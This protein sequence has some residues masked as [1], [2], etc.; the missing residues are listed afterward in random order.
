MTAHDHEPTT[1]PYA[2][3][4]ALYWNAGWRGVLPLPPRA[5]KSPPTG[6]TGRTQDWPT[7]PDVYAWTEDH[8]AGNL[9]LRLPHH[10]IGVDVDDYEGKNGATTLAALEA[11]FGSLPATWRT[12]SRD[13]G[14]SGIRLYRV[15]EGAAWPGDLGPGIE[16]IQWCHRYALVWPSVHPEA[17]TYRWVMPDGEDSI[18]VIPTPDDLPDLP[19]AWVEGLTHGRSDVATIKTALPAGAASVWLGQLQDRRPCRET[20]RA[21]T[22]YTTDLAPAD[23]NP[24]RSRHEVALTATMRLIRLAAEGHHGVPSALLAFKKAWARSLAGSRSTDEENGEWARLLEGAIAAVHTSPPAAA[25]PCANPFAGILQEG[26]WPNLPTPSIPQALATATGPGGPSTA[27]AGATA[28]TPTPAPGKE[29]GSPAA[30][31]GTSGSTSPAGAG[32]PAGAATPSPATSTTQTAEETSSAEEATSSPEEAERLAFEALARHQ[33]L[34]QELERQR[35]QRAAR[36]LLDEEEAVGGD[37]GSSEDWAPS[38]RPQD[39]TAHLDGSYAPEEP[40]LLPRTDG[41]HLLYPGRAHSLHGES[42]SGKSLVAQAEAARLLAAGHPV[43]YI[44]WEAD[45]GAIVGRLL[46]LGAPVAAIREQLTYIRPEASPLAVRERE[47]WEALLAQ[48]YT[49]AV[50]DGV[51][52]AIGTFGAGSTNNDEIATWMR[53][54]PRQIA[55]RTGAAVVQVDHVTKDA[56]TRGRFALGGQAKMNALDGAAYV[57]EIAEPIGRNMR[58]VISLRVAKDRPGQVRPIAGKYRPGDRTQEAAR[59]IVDSTSGERIDI[60]IQAP[61]N[62]PAAGEPEPPFRPTRLMEKASAFLATLPDGAT[63]YAV[64]K[65]VT[66]KGGHIRTALSR[67]VEEGYAR[68]ASGPRNSIVY[69]HVKPYS[70]ALELLTGQPEQTVG[71]PEGGTSSHLV[72]TSSPPRP[73]TRST[74]VPA[75]SS[76][77]VPTPSFAGV[78]GDEVATGRRTSQLYDLVYGDGDEVEPVA[79]HGCGEITDREQLYAG[80]CR[81]CR[82]V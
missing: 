62:L 16:I 38:W 12:T 71:Q 19:A 63:G 14:V 52:D 7:Y 17:R 60:T 22:R 9:A 77:L 64:E 79:C 49:L 26:S 81:R 34:Q 31:S 59:V 20:T 2:H 76:H 13:D 75:T 78:E 28:S 10:V 69:F 18:G 74:P 80:L 56:D 43:L 3:A 73:G 57:V 30:S 82:R 40:T 42:E 66:G 33:L 54:V 25:D 44:D 39:L 55:A 1:G 4:A 51:T 21:L 29:A 58:G 65:D 37:G 53:V 45:A 11:A 15:A 36:R 24:G 46:E 68:R 8:P 35:A 27:T 48:T 6:W 61:A 5:K 67:L 47:D 70:E 72:P 41:A 23:G 50:L 32:A